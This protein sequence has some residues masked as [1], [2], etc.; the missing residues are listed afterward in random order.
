MITHVQCVLVVNLPSLRLDERLDK[1]LQTLNEDPDNTEQQ[2]M[3][4]G[5]ISH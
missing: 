2:T 1:D 3:H 4:N 5:F